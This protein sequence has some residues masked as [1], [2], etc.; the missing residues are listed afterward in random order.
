MAA[1]DPRNTSYWSVGVPTR[2]KAPQVFF[3]A[4]IGALRKLITEIRTKK[5]NHTDGLIFLFISTYAWGKDGVCMKT[6]ADIAKEFGLSRV[7]VQQSTKRLEKAGYINYLYRVKRADEVIE[8]MRD[9]KRAE[10]MGYDGGIILRSF[11]KISKPGFSTQ[12][13]GR[14]KK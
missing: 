13:K 1:S 9:F 3:S 14:F 6:M 2:K 10:R 12:T 8:T 7:T 11:F 5:I 4:E